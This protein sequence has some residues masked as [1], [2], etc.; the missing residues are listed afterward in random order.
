MDK[1][2]PTTRNHLAG[3]S[4]V[5]WTLLPIAMLFLCAE[6]IR[7]VFMFRVGSSRIDHAIATTTLR[8]V[9]VGGALLLLWLGLWT[10]LRLAKGEAARPR[11][12]LIGW[13]G[14][15]LAVLGNA[16]SAWITLP[17][18]A[19]PAGAEVRHPLGWVGGV[20][21]VGMLT[22][23]VAGILSVVSLIVDR[24]RVWG[25]L[26]LLLSLC[27]VPL[28]WAMFDAISAAKGFHITD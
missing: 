20:M 7:H 18:L 17:W 16:W 3:V 10:W 11:H 5:L 21:F 15:G 23:M 24:Q 25:G 22:L 27:P 14:F 4:T 9:P 19:L 28:A 26:G 6:P 2:E 8:L 13:T 12:A 1:P